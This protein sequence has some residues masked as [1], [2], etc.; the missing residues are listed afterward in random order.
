MGL[1]PGCIKTQH[2]QCYK[3]KPLIFGIKNGGLFINNPLL[4]TIKGMDEQIKS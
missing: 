4:M 3:C 2:L 1:Q